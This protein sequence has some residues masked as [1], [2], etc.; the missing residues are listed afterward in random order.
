MVSKTNLGEKWELI[1]CD[2]T[3]TEMQLQTHLHQKR[4]LPLQLKYNQQVGG[5]AYMVSKTN[6]GEKWGLVA[7]GSLLVDYILTVA[8]IKINS[9]SKHAINTL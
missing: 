5:G 6:L 1:L 4:Y 9:T 7:G 8:V 2:D 3:V